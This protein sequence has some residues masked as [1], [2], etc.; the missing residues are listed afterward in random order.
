MSADLCQRPVISPCHRCTYT[1]PTVVDQFT[2]RRWHAHQHA[3]ECPLHPPPAGSAAHTSPRAR[4]CQRRCID[5]CE[6]FPR[7]RW[8]DRSESHI[9]TQLNRVLRP[10][11]CTAASDR[12]L[13][14]DCCYREQTF[15]SVIW[16]PLGHAFITRLLFLF[17][18][19]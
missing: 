14:T 2:C 13:F 6:P 10:P 12:Y 5:W 18:P 19:R 15:S 8:P 4:G 9:V 3:T 1:I 7:G 16:I 11:Q 17:L